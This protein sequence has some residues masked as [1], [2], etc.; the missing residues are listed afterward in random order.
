MGAVSSHAQ[1]LNY[2]FERVVREIGGLVLAKVPVLCGVALVENYLEE[3]AYLRVVPPEKFWE[4]DMDLL[5]KARGLMGRVPFKKV[6]LLIVD[7]IGKNI[8]GAGMDSNVTGR[9]MHPATPEPTEKQFARI[10]VRDLTPQSEGNGLGMGAADFVSKRLVDKLDMEKTRINC[11]TAS[12]PEKGRIPITYAADLPAV[13]DGLAS[14][15]VHQAETARLVWVKNT[16]ELE[17]MWI[18][19]AL[20]EEAK[21]MAN[22][23]LVKG[24]VEFPLDDGGN[25]PFGTLTH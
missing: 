8:S 5:Q 15:G 18:S 20:L 19:A 4:A 14:A 22:L 7:E 6:D 21:A 11:V 25:L 24:P 13:E 9:I 3:T 17:R 16:L 1:F 2:G 10:F 23:E 12:A